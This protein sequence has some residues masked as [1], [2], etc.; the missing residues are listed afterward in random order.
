MAF[1]FP[2]VR[3]LPLLFLSGGAA[4]TGIFS[5]LPVCSRLKG[6]TA[7]QEESLLQ[8]LTEITRVMQEG[9]LVENM[10]PEKKT[11]GDWEGIQP[12]KL[13]RTHMNTEHPPAAPPH[14]HVH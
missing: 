11:Q 7:D 8:Q 2:I 4:E 3:L 13:Q 9:Q 6:V 14:I 12:R 5:F 10:A 1:S